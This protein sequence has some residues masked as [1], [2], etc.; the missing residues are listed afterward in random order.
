MLQLIQ[1]PSP[2]ASIIQISKLW[3]IEARD[4][5]GRSHSQSLAGWAQN[6]CSLAFCFLHPAPLQKQASGS[7]SH[8][9]RLSLGVGL[10]VSKFPGTF[11]PTHLPGPTPKAHTYPLKETAKCQGASDALRTSTY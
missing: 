11:P 2:T 10:G 8:R 1:C 3:L 7:T 9:W 4:C 5:R 6:S